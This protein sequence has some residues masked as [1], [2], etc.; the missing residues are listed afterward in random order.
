M[1]GGVLRSQDLNFRPKGSRS[2]AV[3]P[4]HVSK[5]FLAR[6]LRGQR[7]LEEARDKKN[8]KTDVTNTGKS[9]ASS[10]ART[11]LTDKIKLKGGSANKT[12]STEFGTPRSKIQ[13][14]NPNIIAPKRTT[15][16]TG[17]LEAIRRKLKLESTA[18]LVSDAVKSKIKEYQRSHGLRVDGIVGEQTLN[19]MGIRSKAAPK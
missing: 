16:R 4:T 9:S 18:S 10:L 5:E 19:A 12:S 6:Q 17:E 15:L 2:A 13:I 8:S 3:P 14:D 1:A 11:I 7:A